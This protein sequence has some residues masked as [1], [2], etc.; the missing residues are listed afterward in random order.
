MVKTWRLAQSAV[1]GFTVKHDV[2][3]K[4]TFN[5]KAISSLTVSFSTVLAFDKE[6]KH[7]F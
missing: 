2:S 3:Y 1:L 4:D 6:T 5:K 7:F